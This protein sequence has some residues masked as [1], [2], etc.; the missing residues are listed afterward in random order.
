M[1]SALD[2][3]LF[4]AIDV[5]S[6]RRVK[7]A[8]GDG[9]DHR[10]TREYR[11][12]PLMIAATRDDPDCLLLLIHAGAELDAKDAMGATAL[13]LACAHGFVAAAQALL[14]AGADSSPRN[15]VGHSAISLAE[16]NAGNFTKR[17]HEEAHAARIAR[18]ASLRERSELG[19][20]A[21]AAAPAAAQRSL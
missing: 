14:D 2:H 17:E 10:S 18:L 16:S 7:A 19:L 3:E 5:G 8:L 20:A 21:P 6:T 13:I 4:D 15:C 12:A 1:Q 11:R 9:A